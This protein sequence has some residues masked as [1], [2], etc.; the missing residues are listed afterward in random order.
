[1][2]HSNCIVVALI[3]YLRARRRWRRRGS[4]RGQSP[5]L[6]IRG[7]HDAPG[8]VPHFLV[9]RRSA[10]LRSMPVYS[11]KP[12]HPKPRTWW[13]WWRLPHALYFEGRVVRGD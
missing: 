8:W 9:G 4:P 5:Y 12:L 6:I 1:M 2:A 7:S 3:G 13:R 10:A 11:F